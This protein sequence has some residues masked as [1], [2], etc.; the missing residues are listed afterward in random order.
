MNQPYDRIGKS[1]G[2]LCALRASQGHPFT[3]GQKKN[4]ANL[5]GKANRISN[6]KSGKVVCL[7]V[8]A[9]KRRILAEII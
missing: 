6:R 3:K 2:K 9:A 4:L 7:T 5:V 8:L 1:I